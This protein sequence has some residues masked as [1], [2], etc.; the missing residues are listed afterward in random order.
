MQ[1]KHLSIVNKTRGAMPRVD[2]VRLKEAVLGANYDLSVALVQPA[3]AKR[4]TWET[5]RKKKPSNVLSFPLSKNSGE[6]IICPHTA[7]TQA[8]DYE[9]TRDDFIAYLFIHGMFHI[10]GHEHGA[11]MED[12]ERRVLKRFGLEVEL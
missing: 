9:A 8:P 6:I 7:R 10:K 3:E 1:N 4:V 2:F 5:K 11:T 12:N